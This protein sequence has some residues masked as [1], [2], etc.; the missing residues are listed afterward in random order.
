MPTTESRRAAHWRDHRDFVCI[1]DVIGSAI[2][3]R[4]R[5]RA[6]HPYRSLDKARRGFGF[7]GGALGRLREATFL[8]AP[9]APA[10]ALVVNA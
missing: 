2:H 10:S 6:D 9:V 5:W 7:C 3:L 4:Y 8:A 1:E